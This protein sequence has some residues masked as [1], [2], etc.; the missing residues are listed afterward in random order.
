MGLLAISHS[1][2][3]LCEGRYGTLY[4]PGDAALTSLELSAR[5]WTPHGAQLESSPMLGHTPIGRS[6]T[7]ATLAP[8]Q[9]SVRESK[10]LPLRLGTRRA[11]LANIPLA[12]FWLARPPYQPADVR[13][14]SVH[15][16]PGCSL[17]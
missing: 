6:Q 3:P 2:E 16:H 4:E 9:I 8:L 14:A 13:L 11:Q 10:K 7:I 15:P 5:S 1:A 17:V 12:A